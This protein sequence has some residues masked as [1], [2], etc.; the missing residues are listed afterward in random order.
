MNPVLLAMLC[1]AL[2]I[3]G[4][5]RPDGGARVL[6]T[7]LLCLV[8]GSI[9]QVIRGFVL[10]ASMPRTTW[11]GTLGGSW[12]YLSGY[13]QLSRFASP[14]SVVTVLLNTFVFSI[15]ALPVASFDDAAVAS[16]H[17]QGVRSLWAYCQSIPGTVFLITSAVCAAAI[18][19][20]GRAQRRLAWT[21][22]PYL[23][24]HTAFFVWFN[25]REAF[26]YSPAAIGPFFVVV[27]GASLALRAR[28]RLAFLGLALLV[29]AANNLVVRLSPYPSRVQASMHAYQTFDGGKNEKSSESR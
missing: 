1:I 28:V 14:Q 20:R 11:W 27:F 29:C 26:L 16:M 22:W 24:C 5:R 8:A 4:C 6:R 7:I 9:V 13:G 19:A 2:V 15:G 21:L 23:L 25:P 10:T 12:R 3:D 18:V 17:S